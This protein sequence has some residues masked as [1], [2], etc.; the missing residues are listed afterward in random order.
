MVSTQTKKFPL[1]V[2]AIAVVLV[3]TFL[4]LR[5]SSKSHDSARAELL[6]FAPADATSVIFIDVDQLRDSPFLTT[7]YSWAP[8]PAEDSEYTQFIADTGFNYERD[9]SQ[10]F[11]AISNHG[12]TSNTLVVAEG[13]FDR[14][15]IAAY[16]SKTSPP[17]KPGNLAIFQI[18]AR[19]GAKP[20][21]FAFL[22]DHRVAISD[23]ENLSQVLSA[24]VPASSRAEWQTRFDRLAGSPFFA[25][26]RQ[27][28]AIQNIAANQSPQLAAFIGQLPW[29][30]L[31][32]RPDGE[33]LRVVAE[34]ETITDTASSQLRD[35]LQGIQLL[36]QTGLN[37]PKLR[38]Q[39]DPDKR[40][41]YIELLKRTEIEKIARGD[42]KS[43]RIVLPI[44]AQFLQVVKILPVGAAPVPATDRPETAKSQKGASKQGKA[45][46]TK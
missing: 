5:F 35:F 17:V 27:D 22:S 46:K 45:T 33:I 12:A 37:D 26:I 2:I 32:A 15:K 42:A 40:A 16:L 21:S 18:P 13:K 11:I 29:I 9:L 23:S 39:M 20:A 44:T 24:A 3:A 25:V 31:A 10:V 43:V 14:K 28:P 8:H 41:A 34:G 19:E 6:G 36:A 4:V 30:T 38:Q 7:L 1:A